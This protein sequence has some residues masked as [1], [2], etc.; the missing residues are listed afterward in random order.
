VLQRKRW[1]TESKKAILS[2]IAGC[3][4]TCPFA[5]G[6]VHI[7]FVPEGRGRRLMG[8]AA[9]YQSQCGLTSLDRGSRDLNGFAG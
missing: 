3:T 5:W 6:F 8:G 4:Q 1:G 2:V 9:G 7:P